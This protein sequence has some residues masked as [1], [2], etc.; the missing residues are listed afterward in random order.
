MQ[1]NPISVMSGYDQ[2]F[3]KETLTVQVFLLLR[4]LTA[5]LDLLQVMVLVEMSVRSS[6][7]CCT[8]VSNSQSVAALMDSCIA[9]V[10]CW[11][12]P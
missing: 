6:C 4:V 3:Q 2:H 10:P 1:V 9:T 5:F 7:L 11:N 8:M 12:Q